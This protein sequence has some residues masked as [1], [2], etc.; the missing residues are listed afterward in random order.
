MTTHHDPVHSF[1]FIHQ[2]I[3]AVLIH[4]LPTC[5]AVLYS[6]VFNTAVRYLVLHPPSME[7]IHSAQTIRSGTRQQRCAVEAVTRIPQNAMNA[8]YGWPY[9]GPQCCG[10]HQCQSFGVD[11]RFRFRRCRF[12]GRFLNNLWLEIQVAFSRV[13][14]LRKK[15]LKHAQ[16]S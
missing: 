4:S 2:F 12:I 1:F 8:N 5:N 15:F 7:I 10:A 9:A 16:L 11:F 14:D 6:N 13:T 3:L